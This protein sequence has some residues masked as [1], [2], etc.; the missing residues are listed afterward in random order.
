MPAVTPAAEGSAGN[1]IDRAAARLLEL[2]A[3][4]EHEGR[5]G[6]IAVELTYNERGAVL[7]RELVNLTSK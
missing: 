6:T 7:M 3:R 1:I 2:H 4:A 5:H